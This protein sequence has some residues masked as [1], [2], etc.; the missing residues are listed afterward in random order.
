MSSAPKLAPAIPPAELPP[1]PGFL[2]QYAPK[3]VIALILTFVSG[4]VDIVGYLGIFRFFTAHMTGTTVQLGYGLI[5]RNTRNVFIALSIVLAFLLGS[6][7]GRALIEFASRR[8]IQRV[9]SLTLALEALAL[10]AAAATHV[11]S[12][13]WPYLGLDLLAGAMGLQTAT[14][15]RIGAL[16]VHT[17][18]VTGMINKLAQLLSHLLF[19]ALDTVRVRTE[20]GEAAPSREA[21]PLG[22]KAAEA[23]KRDLQEVVFLIGIWLLYV[24]GAAIGAWSFSVSAMHTLWIG[25]TL[26]ALCLAADQFRPLSI[27]EE[28]EQSEQ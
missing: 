24:A 2:H 15:T 27:Q 21:F 19:R 22:K 14:L 7:L 12:V 16:T 18:F 4:L 23:Q 6:V 28:H 3:I 13:A 20:E 5:S 1:E 8:K 25:A 26:L 11:N 10:I 17:T 9:A